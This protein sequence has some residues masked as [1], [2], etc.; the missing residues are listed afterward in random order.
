[1]YACNLLTEMQAASGNRNILGKPCN[2]PF[3]K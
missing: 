1:M 3:N 2:A